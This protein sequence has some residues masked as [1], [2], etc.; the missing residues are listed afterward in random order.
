MNIDYI[1]KTLK[2]KIVYY[3]PALSGKTTNLESICQLEPN[4]AGK[5]LTLNTELERTVFFDYLLVQEMIRGFKVQ[6]TFYTVPGQR[7]HHVTRKLVL[8]GADAVVFI[9]DSSNDRME[10]NLVALQELREFLV[11]HNLNLDTLP[12]VL[13]LNKRDVETADSVENLTKALRFKGESVIEAVATNLEGVM[14]T[15]EAITKAL[16]SDIKENRLK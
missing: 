7:I 8:S 6:L 10:D 4:A 5:L 2:C 12:Y 9:A 3:G 13:Q 1:G 14:E 15:K 11:G 16:I